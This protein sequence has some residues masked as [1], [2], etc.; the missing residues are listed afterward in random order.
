M[1]QILPRNRPTF[2]EQ[3]TAGVQRGS[4]AASPYL[5]AAFTNQMKQKTSQ[6]EQA[7][8]AQE[9]EV[10]KNS[11]AFS[12]LSPL[13]QL[14]VEAEFKGQLTGQTGK[15]LI[16]AERESQFRPY[17]ERLLGISTERGAEPMG[18]KGERDIVNPTGGDFSAF[19][20]KPPSEEEE[21][22][23]RTPKSQS[24][25][26]K[27]S[28]EDLQGMLA[29]KNT[30][31]LE[32]FANVAE[33]EIKRRQHAE[34]IA[35]QEKTTY[36]K[37]N[38]P[39]L[40]DLN[41]KIRSSEE[42]SLRYERLNKLFTEEG[43]T[44]PSSF[45]A[46]MFDLEGEGGLSKLGRSQLSPGAQEAVKL[47]TDMLS[48]AKDTYGARVTNF[49]AQQ[50]LKRLP[51]L[52]NSPEGK[53]RVLRDLSLLN[54]INLLHRQGILEEF[55]VAGGSGALPYSEAERRAT[56]NHKKEIDDLKDRFVNPNKKAFTSLPEAAAYKGKRIKN[57]DTGEIFISNGE[58]WEPE[59]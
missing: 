4:A 12:N 35:H 43:E 22:R 19:M 20:E 15:S 54:K 47:I 31:G 25:L 52:L 3:L 30:P 21:G 32:G 29:F 58:S 6:A 50:F 34:N 13:Q 27:I 1:V 39:K 10:F 56:K 46:A 37:L 48:G 51:G 18:A 49:D 26:Q 38:E 42:N 2:A 45:T 16:N 44:F 9:F 11:P 55:D 8:K 23:T 36:T 17:L 7:R 41:E 57:K 59:E 33:S 40:A 24:R 53:K 5:E 28:D 14:A